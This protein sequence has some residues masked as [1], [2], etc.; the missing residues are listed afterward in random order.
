MDDPAHVVRGDD[1][2]NGHF[3]GVEVDV[4]LGD[5]RG[6]PEGRIGVAGVGRVVE[7]DARI[8]LE[9]L[10]D[11]R[12][13]IGPGVGP[14]R[15][16]ER[17]AGAGLHLGAQPAT[18]TDDE[19]A[20]DHC[21]PRR[22]GGTRI[23]H[24]RRVDR[25]DL[26]RLDGHPQLRRRE[27][28]E[29]RLRALAHLGRGR[30]DDDRALGGE[31][32]RCYRGEVDLAR[33]GEPGT[34]PRER[35]TDAVGAPVPSA[36]ERGGRDEPGAGPVD[37]RPRGPLADAFVLG[38]L[39]R[40]LEHLLAGDAVEQHLAGRGDVARSVHPLAPQ[41]QRRH[42]ERLGDPVDLHLRGEL[43]LGRPEAPER[44]VR[45]RVRG[46]DPGVD[47]DVGARYGPPACSVPRDRTTG[48]SVQYAP[49]SMRI[50]ISWAMSSPRF[51]TPLR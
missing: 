18:R 6:P 27:L 7:R 37:S 13:A 35:E 15:V 10:V 51:V 3:S 29:D 42:V 17:T 11:P 19:P 40:A 39:G 38:R 28:R 43:G 9:L 24:E 2:P 32:D 21:R 31:L 44:P 48:L 4:D 14:V 30:Q 1:A 23:G 34:V 50:S 46:D 20:H 45:W 5:R 8:G 33:A 25:R 47:A 12:R 41:L 36:V 16:G 49:P 22:H 26:D